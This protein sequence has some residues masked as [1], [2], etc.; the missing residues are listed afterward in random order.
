[1]SPFFYAFLLGLTFIAGIFAGCYIAVRIAREQ[2]I[3]T[4]DSWLAHVTR[5]EDRLAAYTFNTKLIADSL[6]EAVLLMREAK[7]TTK[8]A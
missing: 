1:M 4:M 3:K 2:H 5:V 7:H 6:A 8:E